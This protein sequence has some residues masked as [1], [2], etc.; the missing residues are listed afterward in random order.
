MVQPEIGDGVIVLPMTNAQGGSRLADENGGHFPTPTNVVIKS[1]YFMEWMITNDQSKKIADTF[2]DENEKIA[3]AQKLLTI[4]SF[5]DS[6]TYSSRA[7]KKI[8]EKVGEFEGF[9]IY[10]YT[11]NFYSFEKM[12]NSGIGFRITFKLGDFSLKPHPFM[13]VLIPLSHP[14]IEIENS[15]G[16]VT[17]GGTV[18]SNCVMKWRPTKSDIETIFITLAHASKDHRN[19]LV[20]IL[21]S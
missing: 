15:N 6:S 14:L 3:L 8:H 2:L 1:T 18:G 13:F 10:M 4:K 11:E 19:D 21:E 16:P 9:T 12:T 5:A 20:K 17:V 7:V